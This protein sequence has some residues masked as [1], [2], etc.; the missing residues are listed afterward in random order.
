M[1]TKNK[2]SVKKGMILAGGLGTRFLPATL[3]LAKELFP[4]GNKPIIMYHLEDLAKAG[5][6]DILIVGNK[7]KEESF[8]QFLCPSEAYIAQVEADGK[9]P[10]LKDYYETMKNLKITYVNQDDPT[11][12]YDGVTYPNEYLGERGSAIAIGAAKHWAKDEPFIC[13]NGDDLCFYPDGKSMSAEVIGVHNATGDTVVYG[14]EMPRELIWKYSSMVLGDGVPGIKKASKVHDIIEKP[15][16]GTE[17]STLMG[18]CRYVLD[19]EFFDRIFKIK[20]RPNGEWNMTDVLQSLAQSG[21]VST[22]VFDGDYFDC[23]S[24]TGYALANVYT[25]NAKEE[26]K[27]A[28]QNGMK[29]I[30]KAGETSGLQK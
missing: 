30:L 4:I 8:K 19:K 6:N 21:K 29:K 27:D 13:L 10:L 7:L 5:V 17:P 11:F 20:Q 22:V 12:T 3:C 1:E 2:Q 14:K 9:L 15:A 25:V 24:D 18:F 26:S 23:G 28:V 16:K